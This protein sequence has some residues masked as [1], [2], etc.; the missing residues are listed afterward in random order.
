MMIIGD[1]MNI[2]FIGKQVIYTMT[3]HCKLASTSKIHYDIQ[4]LYIHHVYVF[5]SFIELASFMYTARGE[6]KATVFP[7]SETCVLQ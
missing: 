7:I 1:F 4:V 5:V 6:E 2:K 3:L